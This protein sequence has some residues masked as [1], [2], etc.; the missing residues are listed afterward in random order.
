MSLRIFDSIDAVMDSIND[1]SSLC[2][3]QEPSTDML[4]VNTSINWYCM[5]Q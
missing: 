3:V 2:T 5:L 1:F 4:S